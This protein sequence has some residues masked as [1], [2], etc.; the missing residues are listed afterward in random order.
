M[1]AI[2]HAHSWLCNYYGFYEV[3]YQRAN[4]Q[5]WDISKARPNP[6]NAN[7]IAPRKLVE[8]TIQSYC[9]GTS[10]S[11]NEPSTSLFEYSLDVMKIARNRGL[12]NTY[13]TNLYSTP[14]ALRMIVENGCDAFCANIKGDTNMVKKYCGVDS[15]II[16]RN[17]KELKK[18][19][20]H[21]EVVTLVIPTLNDDET[22]LRSIARRIRDELGARVPWHC[23][24]YF[25]AYKSSELALPYQTPLS[26]L[27]RAME[28]GVEEELEYVYIGNVP[29]HKGENTYCPVCKNLLIERIGMTSTYRGIERIDNSCSKCH[30]RIEMVGKCL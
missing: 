7:Y 6:S 8:T 23:T 26:S 3:V 18:C 14:R 1:D 2:L 22:T 13:V 10:F 15:E 11:F 28:I 5:N 25:A 24:R 4:C 30:T 21:V 17:L 16:W 9:S 20:K 19:G 27:E 29:G 12:Y